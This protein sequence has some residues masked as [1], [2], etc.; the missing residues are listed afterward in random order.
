MDEVNRPERRAS[1][2]VV[3]SMLLTSGADHD[4][5]VA[6]GH[7]LPECALRR[8]A[9][10]AGQGV[11]HR[12]RVHARAGHRRDDGD[13]RADPGCAAAAAAGAGAGPAG[14]R[15]ARGAHR[16]LRAISLRQHRDRG[17]RPGESASRER[18]RCHAQW[19]PPFGRDRRQHLVVCQCRP[20]YRWV[21]RGARGT[22]SAGTRV[23]ARRRSRRCGACRRHQP[24]LL[25]ASLRGHAGRHR[26]SNRDRRTAVR[27]RRRD[28]SRSRLPARRRDLEDDAIGSDRWFLRDGGTARGQSDR[29]A[30]RRRDR[31]AGLERARG[32][33]P[34]TRHRCPCRL[35]PPWLQHRRSPLRRGGD[36]R[37]AA[38]DDCA[39][40]RCRARAADRRCQRRQPVADAGRE[41]A[42]RAGAAGG[43]RRGS[44]P[45]RRRSAGG[46]PRAVGD[47]GHGRVPAGLGGAAGAHHH[48]ARRVAANRVHP[49]RRDGRR[50]FCG[51]GLRHRPGC[52]HRRRGCS[53]CAAISYHPC[54]A[55]ARRSPACRRA[56]VDCSWWDRLR[57]R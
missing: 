31:R 35:P 20:D 55:A 43:A 51:G 30:A 1:P 44:W 8:A 13:V 34:A 29:P 26:P 23:H 56:G 2:A 25:A 21:L 54:E 10:V 12:R 7:G 33:G 28:A 46:E 40:R 16:G 3:C 11:H 18:G 42:R 5:H 6:A 45:H 57:W 49:H 41:P 39:L 22:G 14:P 52:R 37:C 53:R 48:R 32:A 27:H 19:R 9:A 50:I 15:V 4:R 24:R 38:H 36:R 47:C 17:Y